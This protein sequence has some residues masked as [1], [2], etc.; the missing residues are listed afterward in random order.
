MDMLKIEIRN[1][2]IRDERWDKKIERQVSD[3]ILYFIDWENI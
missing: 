1:R 3:V 2:M